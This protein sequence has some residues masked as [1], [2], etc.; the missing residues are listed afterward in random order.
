MLAEVW[1][2]VPH[3]QN[4][5]I[6]L[7]QLVFSSSHTGFVWAGN[8]STEDAAV[9]EQGKGKKKPLCVTVGRRG[10]AARPERIVAP[11]AGKTPTS[12]CLAPN[13]SPGGCGPPC[14]TFGPPL[15]AP[16]STAAR[17]A[18]SCN[19]P[20]GPRP[21]MKASYVSLG[22]LSYQIPSC[23]ERYAFKA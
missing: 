7:Q 19:L 4:G 17:R 20:M 2:L 18:A 3:V 12:C 1:G 23:S 13:L 11:G 15:T 5:F 16:F 9:G 6:L 22:R 14:P 21:S 8:T 10:L